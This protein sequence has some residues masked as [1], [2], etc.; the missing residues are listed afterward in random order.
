MMNKFL[1]L[2][3]SIA[4]SSVQATDVSSLWN[5]NDPV[6]D[7]DTATNTFTI[8]YLGLNTAVTD[9]TYG[10]KIWFGSFGCK[11]DAD[12][13]TTIFE[14]T[15]AGFVQGT[16][17]DGSGVDVTDWTSS[18]TT[19]S[20]SFKADM[21]VISG[22]TDYY[23]GDGS[24]G[25][26]LQFCVRYSICLEPACTNEVNFLE[27]QVTVSIS[28]DGSFDVDSL[29]VAPKAKTDISDNIA[30]TV[31]AEI[32]TAKA[33]GTDY[34]A[35]LDTT[36]NQGEVISV[37][38]FPNRADGSRDDGIIMN[39]VTDFTWYLDE[40]TCNVVDGVVPETGCTKQAAVEGGAPSNTLTNIDSTYAAAVW[41]TAGDVEPKIVVQSVL[42]ATFFTAQNTAAAT[43]SALMAFPARRRQLR[44][45]SSADA[46]AKNDSR[47]LADQAFPPSPFDVSA[48]LNAAMDTPT[49]LQTAAGESRSVA[50][51]ASLVGLATAMLFA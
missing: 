14:S 44:E 27:T 41:A 15:K 31:Q 35:S 29:T 50:T 3:S 5:I 48:G 39:S 6:P 28:M 46:M 37:C 40:A 2:L 7:V 10:Q 24:G 18:G 26:T 8:P 47:R 36:F 32:C 20:L 1:L 17:G 4:A 38:I 42:F 34:I 16:T 45:G 21:S 13:A 30:Y 9:G 43:G 51:V 19:S 11:D 23:T 49:L 33:D 12:G 22:L 25:G